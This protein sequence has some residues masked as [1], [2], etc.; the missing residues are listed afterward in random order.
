MFLGVN[1][2]STTC[3]ILTATWSLALLCVACPPAQAQRERGELRLEVRDSQGAVL[4]AK[5][6]LVSQS[7]QFERSFLVGSDGRYAAQDLP[8]GLY[9]LTL[10]AEGFAPWSKTVEVRSEVP[11]RLSVTLGVAPVT[12]QVQV[13]DAAT[14]IDPSQSGAV[15]PIGKQSIDEQLPQQP[16]RT[17]SDLVDDQPGWLYEANGILHPRGSEYDVQYVFDGLPLTQ[18]RSPA[19]AP[20]FDADDVESMRVLTAGFPAEYGRKLGGIVEVTTQKDVP[21]GWHGRLDAAGGSFASV[22]GSG[23]VSYARR[24][25]Q[26]SM[27]GYGFSTDR[28]LDPPVLANFTNRG[29]TAGLSASYE[30]DFTDRDRLR[31]SLIHSE[32]RSLVPNELVQQEA[33]QRQDVANDETAGQIYFQHTF[34][35]DLLL[36]VN[37]SVRDVSASLRSNALATPVIVSQERGYREGYVRGDLAGHAGHHDW[38]LGADGIF[39]PVHEQLQ[40][41]ITDASQFDAGTLPAFV[42]PL[43]RKWDVETSVYAQDQVH[44][45]HWNA[46]VGLRFDHYDFVVHESAWSPRVAISRYLPSLGLL[47]HV[48][49]DRVFQT[50]AVENLLLASSPDLGVVN[51]EVLRLPVRPARANYY[52]G[53]L[54]KAFAGKL[55]LDATVFRRDFHNYSDDDVLLDTGVSFPIAFAKGRVFGEEVRI[56]VPQWGAFS[57]YVSYSNQSAIGRGPVTGGLFLGDDASGALTD[58][59]RFASSQDQRNTLRAKIRFAATRR[60]WLAV[61]GAYG[62]GLPVELDSGTV[63]INFLR[64]QFGPA[65]VDQVNFDKGRVRPNLSIDASAGA[66]IY[67]KEHRSASLQVTVG[68]LADRV[69]VI[70]FASLF[71]GT[72]VAAPRSASASLRLS[73]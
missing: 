62:S 40:Y 59:G 52:E 38:K 69:N 28:Y 54:T 37:V 17:L 50:P 49:Y 20:A 22:S 46:S 2:L 18:N 42:F 9:R 33:G 31:V 7:N 51:P 35:P 68:N 26:F 3:K 63:D 60:M 66:E 29:T 25:D 14:L 65:I 57:G 73:F 53:G 56:A 72:A 70:N 48:S 47:L 13:N 6:Q 61:G 71:S 34:S 58:M 43:H 55:R 27:S 8:F 45:G 4:A 11:L 24:D 1:P 30:R 5:G 19:F 15:S 23:A 10:T 41:F 12:T 39:S 16:G 21:G 67:R 32:A 36:S 64:A 44:L